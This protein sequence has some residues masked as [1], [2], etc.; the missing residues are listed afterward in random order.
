ML[1]LDMFSTMSGKLAGLLALNTDTTTNEFCIKRHSRKALNNIC[2]KCYSFAM[3]LKHRKNCV[4]KFQRNSEFLSRVEL[5][6]T[7]VP[8][9]NQAWVRFSGHGELINALHFANLCTIA[10][11]NPHCNFALWTKRVTIVRNHKGQIPPNL[12]LVFSN[13]T[14]GKIIDPPRG[15]HKSFNN[16]NT[17]STEIAQGSLHRHDCTGQ[18]CIDC[19]AC[20]HHNGK[21]VLIENVK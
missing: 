6:F 1:T 18:K 8:V 12:I 3:L 10:R 5:K 16:V 11:K 2:A 21:T 9:I 17:G 13:P 14:I 7:D 4:P 15:F 20:Y 19:L